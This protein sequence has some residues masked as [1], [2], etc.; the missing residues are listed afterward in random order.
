MW[1]GLQVNV[2][3]TAA[4]VVVSAVGEID[5]ASSPLLGREL[6]RAVTATTAPSV[7]CCDL[8]EATFLDSSG[9]GALVAAHKIAHT[10]GRELW[11]GGAHGA[12]LRALTVTALD[13]VL[14]LYDSMDAVHAAIADRTAINHQRPGEPVGR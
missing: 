3:A 4:V 6:E 10:N 12:V 5:I 8:S 2:T 7:I 14:T 1:I 11:I 9:M 13:R